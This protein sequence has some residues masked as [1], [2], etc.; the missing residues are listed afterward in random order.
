MSVSLTNDDSTQDTP[1]RANSNFHK[2]LV[3]TQWTRRWCMDSSSIWHKKHLF[4]KDLPFFWTWSKVKTFLHV[5]FQAKKLTLGCT[6][7][8]HMML[9]CSIRC[10]LFF[11][12]SLSSF[13]RT[14]LCKW[15]WSFVDER[16]ALWKQV[17]SGK[18]RVEEGGCSYEVRERYSVGL[19]KAIRKE[20]NLLS[21]RILFLVGNGQRVR[22]WKDKWCGDNSLYASFPSLSTLAILKKA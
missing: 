13:N 12:T 17:I 4:A 2:T 16:G 10:F 6:N 20:W 8:F 5:A 15:C 1:K 11:P 14:L 19:L 7:A 9:S 21:C 22:F 18:Y 3:F